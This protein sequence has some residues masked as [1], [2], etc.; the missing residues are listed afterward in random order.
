MVTP[1]RAAAHFVSSEQSNETGLGS[2]ADAEEPQT[3]GLPDWLRAVLTNCVAIGFVLA[4]AEGTPAVDPIWD[5]LTCES[6]V[7]RSGVPVVPVAA[8]APVRPERLDRS[9]D[10]VAAWVPMAELNIDAKSV[11][12][13]APDVD[14]PDETG[15]VPEAVPVAETPASC[16]SIAWMRAWTAAMP[17]K[18]IRD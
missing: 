18:V 2:L 14:A 4:P 10:P 13:D 9:V 11:D 17:S 7:E 12:V 8:P 15:A 6:R 5:P 3:Y 16:C 1:E